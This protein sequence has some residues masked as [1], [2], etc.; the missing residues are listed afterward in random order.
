MA[1][2]D[3]IIDF[4]CRSNNVRDICFHLFIKV[5]ILAPASQLAHSRSGDMS[6]LGDTDH[7]DRG[8]PPTPRWDN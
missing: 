6:K 7:N 3:R 2:S 8:T 5:T 4:Q 1:C